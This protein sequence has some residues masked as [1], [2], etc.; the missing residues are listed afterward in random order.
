MLKYK[1]NCKNTELTEDYLNTL[2]REE[3]ETLFE[4]INSVKFIANLISP[5][6]ENDST[7]FNFKMK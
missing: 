1:T 3:R 2:T 5:N 6:Q 7:N 4:Y